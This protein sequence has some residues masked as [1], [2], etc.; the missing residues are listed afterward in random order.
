MN[1]GS[2]SSTIDA[3]GNGDNG[4]W[5]G[6][7]AGTNSTYYT[8]GKVGNYAG[9]F[10]GSND[11]VNLGNP[12]SLQVSNAISVTAWIQLTTLSSANL[13]IMYSNRMLRS[14]CGR[15]RS[16]PYEFNH[17]NGDLVSSDMHL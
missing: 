7:A 2:G 11:Y 1:D 16:F 6:T 12:S 17:Y 9:A 5:N 15:E 4:T 13:G 8:G 10:N 3:S 14:Q